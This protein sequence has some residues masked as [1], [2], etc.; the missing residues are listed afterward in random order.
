MN[1]SQLYAYG[2]FSIK[3]QRTGLPGNNA[4]DSLVFFY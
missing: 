4:Y 3:V 2:F 1:L